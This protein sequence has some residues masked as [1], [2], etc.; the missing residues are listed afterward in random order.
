MKL[1][2]QL[3]NKHDTSPN[4]NPNINYQILAEQLQ[5]TKSKHMPKTISRFNQ[6]KQKKKKNG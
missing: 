6:L 4:G 1:L 2:M 5:Y 3:N